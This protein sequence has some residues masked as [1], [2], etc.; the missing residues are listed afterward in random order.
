MHQFFLFFFFYRESAYSKVPVKSCNGLFTQ[1]LLTAR[2]MLGVSR[3]FTEDLH[4]PGVTWSFL[5]LSEEFNA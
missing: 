5:Y 2:C 3:L 1:N 4:T